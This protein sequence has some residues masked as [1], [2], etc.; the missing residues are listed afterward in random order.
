MCP[1]LISEGPG[2]ARVCWEAPGKVLAPAQPPGVQKS[3]SPSRT[4]YSPLALGK[5]LLDLEADRRVD[6]PAEGC[7]SS[8]PVRAEGTPGLWEAVGMQPGLGQGTVYSDMS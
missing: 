5:V 7:V 2:R 4:T 6:V 1:P 8:D 3:P